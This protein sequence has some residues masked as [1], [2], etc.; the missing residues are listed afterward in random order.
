MGLEAF[1]TKCPACSRVRQIAQAMTKELDDQE[2]I[3]AGGS[4]EV[5]PIEINC[6]LCDGKDGDVLTADG[7]KLKSVLLREF[8]ARIDR[9][10][11]I[12][13]EINPTVA[14]ANGVMKEIPF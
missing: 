12:A 4:V 3:G 1:V 2:S 5:S 10:E 9:L 13:H 7:H 14:E 11:K 6:G 8:A